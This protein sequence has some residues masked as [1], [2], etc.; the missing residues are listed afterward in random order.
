MCRPNIRLGIGDDHL[1]CHTHLTVVLTE[2][3]G[4]GVA[5]KPIGMSIANAVKAT[6]LTADI[7]VASVAGGFSIVCSSAA[8][9]LVQHKGNVVDGAKSFVKKESLFNLTASFL[10]TGLTEGVMAGFSLETAARTLRN[11]MNGT[12]RETVNAIQKATDMTEIAK[13]LSVIQILGRKSIESA[14][15]RVISVA[16]GMEIDAL[17]TLKRIGVTK[18]AASSCHQIGKLYGKNVYGEREI[19]AIVHK[20][21]HGFVGAASGTAISKDPARGALA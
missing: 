11:G 15:S 12:T 5:L 16:L 13:R 4:G 9:L 2:G 21:L 6:G 3:A 17:D 1:G 10:T 18:L 14:S 20:V 19:N 7:I 8:V